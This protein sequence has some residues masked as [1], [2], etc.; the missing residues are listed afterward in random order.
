[1]DRR[2]EAVNEWI[3][4]SETLPNDRQHVIA[5]DGE[6][7]GEFIYMTP[8]FETDEG[9]RIKATHW[10]LLPNPPEENNEYDDIL[11]QVIREGNE[12][13]ASSIWKPNPPQE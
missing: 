1:M 8:Y 6:D 4:V 7:V 11:N 13:M 2:N 9:Y 12:K 10:M 3:K 5:S